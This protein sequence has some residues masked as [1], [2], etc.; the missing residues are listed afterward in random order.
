MKHYLL[1]KK[2]YIDTYKVPNVSSLYS[3]TT[4]C[5]PYSY[6][7]MNLKKVLIEVP[8][9][10]VKDNDGDYYFLSCDLD[11]AER[12]FF[13]SLYAKL[14][15]DYIYKLEKDLSNKKTFQKMK[16]FLFYLIFFFIKFY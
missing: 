4:N 3:R 6:T 14:E 10:Y 8:K 1:G 2:K 5:N 9:D 11:I 13:D 12:E 15:C 7:D 16:C